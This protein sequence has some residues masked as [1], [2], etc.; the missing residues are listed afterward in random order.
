MHTSGSASHY[1]KLSIALHWFTLLLM[2]AIYVAIE[3][4][5]SLPRGH[6][7]RGPM[8]DWHIYL[9]VCLLPIAIFRAIVILRS[10]IPAIVP[11]PPA[12]QHKL[13]L[14]VKAYLYVLM[15]GTP[16]IGW[17]MV[18]AEG[19]AVTL[20]GLALPTVVSASEGLAD[21]A[22][23]AHELLGV[24]GYFFIGLHAIAALYHHYLVKD[25]TLRRMLPSASRKV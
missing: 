19:H 2:I 13:T 1:P 3:M 17:I 24:S 9:G 25:N 20:W 15:I 22:S 7:L 12:W 8:E 23:E 14:A 21:F 18:N 16:L 10:N 6:A 4:H 11:P 5:E